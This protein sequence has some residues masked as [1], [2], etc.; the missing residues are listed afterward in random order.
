MPFPFA[1]KIL[2]FIGILLC[3]SF[4]IAGQGMRAMKGD[5][6]KEETIGEILCDVQDAGEK[7]FENHVLTNIE[8]SR[9]LS[10]GR[11]TTTW[12][13]QLAEVA[14]QEERSA[15]GG[16]IYCSGVFATKDGRVYKFRRHNKQLLQISGVSG[17][18]WLVIEGESGPR[19]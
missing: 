13:A 4:L 17:G 6:P 3:P 14:K 7:G 15:K 5:P 8:L 16:P 12:D 19:K 10:K 2:L 9:F 1:M 18:G 11:F